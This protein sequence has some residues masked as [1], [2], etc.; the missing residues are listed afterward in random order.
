MKIF[1]VV[2]YRTALE[3]KRVHKMTKRKKDRH[4][5]NFEEVIYRTALNHLDLSDNFC[6]FAWNNKANVCT[7]EWTRTPFSARAMHQMNHHHHET[8]K[9]SMYDQ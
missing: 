1:T 4:I 2:I 7:D 9:D 5:K 6:N 3:P 8:D